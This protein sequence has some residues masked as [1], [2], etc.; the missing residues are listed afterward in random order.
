MNDYIE[1]QSRYTDTYLGKYP[2]SY[3][4][5]SVIAL[6][7]L[8]YFFNRNYSNKVDNLR[9]IINWMNPRLYFGGMFGVMP[10]QVKEFL[11]KHGFNFSC[12]V[13]KIDKLYDYLHKYDGN[14]FIVMYAEKETG[15][16]I[17]IDNVFCPHNI[18]GKNLHQIIDDSPIKH[19]IIFNIHWLA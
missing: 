12:K 17:F 11:K 8:T 3:N 2:M 18:Y 16:Y 10:W 13:I 1:Y 15:H 9:Y 4:G 5:C 6:Y 7:N 19:C 14:V